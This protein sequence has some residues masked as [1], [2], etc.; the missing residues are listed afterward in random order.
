MRKPTPVTT[1]SMTQVSGSIRKPR[2]TCRSPPKN[3]RYATTVCGMGSDRIWTSTQIEQRKDARTEPQASR[4]ATSSENRWPSMTFRPLAMTASSG[5]TGMRITTRSNKRRLP[6]E[7][8]DLIHIRGDLPA[9][10]HDDDRQPHRGL[11]CGD[12]DHKQRH[13][14]P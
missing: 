12:G 10:H 13:D 8:V 4:C 3:H 2:L 9:E 14:L 11:A 6:F 7:K 1:S 5:K